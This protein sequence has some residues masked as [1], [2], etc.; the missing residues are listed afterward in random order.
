MRRILRSLPRKV[1]RQM[2]KIDEKA[3]VTVSLNKLERMFYKKVS[4]V[5]VLFQ[6]L[7]VV[8]PIRSP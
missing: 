3:I 5:A 4:G 6:R 7:I 1:N 8:P 2:R